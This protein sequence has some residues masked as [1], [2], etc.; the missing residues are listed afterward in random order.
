MDILEVLD[1]VR[2]LLQQKGRI[3]YR[4]LK[5]QF[6][7]DDEHFEALK[8]ELLYSHPEV[9]DDEGRGFI[10]KSEREETASSS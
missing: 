1:Q 10:W 3:T 4:I 7:L 9:V 8:E 6:K 2:G 5:L